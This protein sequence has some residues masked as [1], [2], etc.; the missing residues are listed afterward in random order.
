MR[1]VQNNHNNGK[2]QYLNSALPILIKSYLTIAYSISFIM[3]VFVLLTNFLLA[4]IL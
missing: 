4:T 2:E 1:S 3:T